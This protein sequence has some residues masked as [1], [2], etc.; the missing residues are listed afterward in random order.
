[1]PLLSDTLGRLGLPRLSVGAVDLLGYLPWALLIAVGTALLASIPLARHVGR[2][3][4]VDALTDRPVG[5]RA[6][7]RRRASASSGTVSSRLGVPARI[8]AP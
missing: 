2:M 5:H 3:S 7:I 1:M 6:G 4:P 8:A